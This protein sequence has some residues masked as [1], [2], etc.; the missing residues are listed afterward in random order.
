[1]SGQIL[2]AFTGRPD[3]EARL[4]E[5][6]SLCGPIAR[7]DPALVDPASRGAIRVVVTS[8]TVGAGAALIDALP[9]LELI[10]CLGS[11]FEGVDM[12]AARARGIKVTFSPGANASSVADHAMALLLASVRKV[13]EGDRFVRSGVWPTAPRP[14]IGPG[15]TGRR[16]GVFGLGAIGE[17]IA[18]RARA[19]EMEVAYHNR[20]PRANAPWLYFDTLRGLAEYSDF[21]VVSCRADEATRGLVGADVLAA[22]GA[23]GHVVNIARGSVIDE[24]ALVAALGSGALAGAGLDVFEN[25]PR[26]SEAL[27]ALPNM[28]MTPHLG[29]TADDARVAMLEMMIGN[30]AA[31]FA[32]RT[33]PNLAEA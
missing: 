32:G 12:K 20:R 31:F 9:N 16:L 14:T 15:L 6:G 5:L 17:K 25:E 10:A 28:V 24:K 7:P 8:G 30:L 3:V 27:R 1:M 23:G 13:A 26:V 29:G 33:P 21:L 4:R 19:F 2:L 22:L 11:G 18:L